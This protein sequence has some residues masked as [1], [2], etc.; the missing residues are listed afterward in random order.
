MKEKNEALTVRSAMYERLEK[1]NLALENLETFKKTPTKTTGKFSFNP[2]YT[3]RYIDIHR[4]NQI[5]KLI[6]ILGFLKK[7]EEEYNEAIAA[8]RANTPV[9][10]FPVFSWLGYNI[11]A[12][13]HDIYLRVTTLNY[14]VRKKKLVEAK[15][16]LETFFS[17]EDRL[18]SVIDEVDN[19]F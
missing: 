10:S 5:E 6:S 4:E 18:K 7:K 17:E 13:S 14:F 8:I 2:D 9:D 3:T 15:S 16:K 12:W 1:I 11:S 19:L